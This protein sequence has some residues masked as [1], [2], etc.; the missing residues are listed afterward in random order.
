MND[1]SGNVFNL[2]DVELESDG[3]KEIAVIF[4]FLPWYV[5]VTTLYFLNQRH[6][7]RFKIAIT[8]SPRR[9]EFA[10]DGYDPRSFIAFVFVFVQR[11]RN[12][13]I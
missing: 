7:I 12:L 9:I 8:K 1:S 10:I 13:S 4:F 6:V 2:L 3:T 5:T 11:T